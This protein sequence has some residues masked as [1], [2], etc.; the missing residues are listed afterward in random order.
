MKINST[1][2]YILTVLLSVISVSVILFN[3]GP[4]LVFNNGNLDFF[5]QKII[6]A[7]A[8][9]SYPR[10][11]YDREIPKI[12]EK[13]FVTMEQAFA[14]TNIIQQVDK[15][16][17]YCHVLGHELADIETRKNPDK[18]LDVITR[19]PSV[20][21]NNGCEHGAVMRRFKG[22]DVL[23]DTQLTAIIP[24][25]K[26][27]CEPRGSWKPTEVERS[28]CYHSLGHLGM[29]ITDANIGKSLS[30]CKQVAVKDD[31]R[32]YYQ[33]CVQGVFMIIFQS[34]DK[35][36]EALVAKIKPKKEDVSSFCSKYTG[37]EFVA[38]RTEAWPYFFS[39][40]NKPSGLANFCSFAVGKYYKDWCYDTGLRGQLSLNILGSLGVDGVSK[41]CLGLPADIQARCFPSVATAWVQDEPHYIKDSI[42]LCKDAD[43]YGY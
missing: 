32:S 20:Q 10:V 3:R 14:V 35:D 34:I 7:C 39:D 19:C 18:W 27:A 31:G 15:S 13:G 25:L 30:I 24:D 37:M 36:D 33:T 1:K 43:K 41:Y 2:I 8:K 9:D 38:C 40:F 5:A 23:S 12:L 26:I 42:N 4:F 28:M 16:Y 22:S 6:K 21:C 11:C 29:Y 17:L